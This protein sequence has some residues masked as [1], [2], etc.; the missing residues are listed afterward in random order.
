MVDLLIT[1]RRV[2]DHVVGSFAALTDGPAQEL[3]PFDDIPYEAML[4]GAMRMLVARADIT[5]VV[6]QRTERAGIA[7]FRL[8]GETVRVMRE[9]PDLALR[10]LT[11]PDQVR[12]LR[13]AAPGDAPEGVL[14]VGYDALADTFGDRVCVRREGNKGECPACGRWGRLQPGADQLDLECTSVGCLFAVPV[15]AAG[16]RWWSVRVTDLL[17]STLRPR[18]FLPRAWNTSGKYITRDALG[19]MLEQ[20][21]QEKRDLACLRPTQPPTPS[22]K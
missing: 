8:D 15:H 9:D 11:Y 22:S 16:P 18:F 13:R 12:D 5:G 3:A 14:R 2:G 10:V 6:L 20:W 7:P 17:Q 19:V 4:T 21:H 1:F